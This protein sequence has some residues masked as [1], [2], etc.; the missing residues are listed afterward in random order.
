MAGLHLVKEQENFLFVAKFSQTEKI[1]RGGG[2][3][4]AF[5][6]D[7][8]DQDR[9]GLRG[10]RGPHRFEIV[11]RHLAKARHHRFKTFLDLFLPGRRDSRQGSAMERAVGGEN[12]VPSTIVAELSCQLV[13]PFVR[14]G[15][16]VAKEASTRPDQPNESFSQLRLW[17]G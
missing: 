10:N 16:A 4:P 7:C 12:F 14:L 15:A 1:F 17:F 6:L 11:E 13:E 9:G 2:G 3:D 5:T 8:F